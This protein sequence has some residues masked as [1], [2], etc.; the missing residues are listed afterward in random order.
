MKKNSEWP[1]TVPAGAEFLASARMQ[2]F[3]EF[4][5]PE[6]DPKARTA[7]VD[8]VV[9]FKNLVAI[10]KVSR[11]DPQLAPAPPPQIRPP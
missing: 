8:E 2:V 11:T 5:G 1:I 7:V 9:S 10:P 6:E 3:A 4:C